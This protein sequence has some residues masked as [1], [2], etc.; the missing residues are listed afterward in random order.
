ML[1][2]GKWT[3]VGLKLKTTL[4]LWKQ[5]Q[6]A[7]HHMQNNSADQRGKDLSTTRLE[8]ES[9]NL[10]YA[11]FLPAIELELEETSIQAQ[12]DSQTRSWQPISPIQFNS[13]FQFN[14]YFDFVNV[15][16]I[17]IHYWP[18]SSTELIDA[19][20]WLQLIYVSS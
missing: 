14:F 10:S 9:A 15:Y 2:S 8:R 6:I 17:E 13:T 3:D 12:A 18:A 19:G 7:K 5:S 11:R 1:F 16:M 4:H 20:Q